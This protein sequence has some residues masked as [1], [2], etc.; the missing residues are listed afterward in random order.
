[1]N[2]E[3]FTTQPYWIIYQKY[4]ILFDQ[5]YTRKLDIPSLL[6]YSKYVIDI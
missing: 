6:E 3:S 1:M 5:N 4:Q 2:N